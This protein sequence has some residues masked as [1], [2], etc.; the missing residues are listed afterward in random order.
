[1]DLL[2]SSWLDDLGKKGQTIIVS[3]LTKDNLSGL[4]SNLTL[5][6]T[7]KFDRKISGKGAVR[8]GEGFTVSILKKL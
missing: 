4:I 3:P 5:G 7:N 6:A 2:H 1:M 8:A